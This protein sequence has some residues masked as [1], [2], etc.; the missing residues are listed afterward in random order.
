MVYQ[1]LLVFGT[2]NT[3]RTPLNAAMRNARN[4][5]SE[6]RK[7]GVITNTCCRAKFTALKNTSTANRKSDDGPLLTTRANACPAGG[8]RS[9]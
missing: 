4:K 5:S 6:G 9:K 2:T 8:C 1:W 3:T 7:Y